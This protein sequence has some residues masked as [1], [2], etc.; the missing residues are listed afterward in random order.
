MPLWK[1]ALP[2]EIRRGA[3]IAESFFDR[4][5]VLRDRWSL[6]NNPTVNG[7]LTLNG[8]NQS[9]T[10]DLN[11]ELLSSE[12]TIEVEFSP[13]FAADDNSE[14]Y[15]VDT[16]GGRTIIVKGSTNT[17]AIY[18]G[19]TTL[20]A[21]ISFASYGS[22]WKQ[23]DRNLLTIAIA[24]G[25]NNIYL[26][27]QTLVSG[28]AIVWVPQDPTI[29]HLGSR[30]TGAS[31]FGG[32]IADFRVG[33]YLSTEQE[34]LD[35][36]NHQAWKW[37]NQSDITLQL[38][39]ADYD[40]TNVQT[41]DSSG[42]GNHFQLGDGSTPTTYPTQEDGR[43]SFDGGDSLRRSSV[44]QPAAAFSVLCTVNSTQPGA[45]QFVASHNNPAFSA[46]NWYLARSSSNQWSWYVGG[47]AVANASIGPDM[48]DSSVHTLVGVYDGTDTILYIDG[49]A[50]T[51][52]TTPL[53]PSSGT[54]TLELGRRSGSAGNHLIGS[55]F[56][57]IYFDNQA[58][59]PV[60]I[61]DYDRTMRSIYGSQV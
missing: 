58:L 14:H 27:G 54:Q 35:R 29:L 34:H 4:A 23:D 49:V 59:T 55:I 52:A 30:F 31:Y 11:G 57:F 51:P 46:I 25:N 53:A 38:R 7:G 21:A 48:P 5:S 37:Q 42:N 40:I 10:Y 2:A 1:D 61:L 26:N 9:A 6:I 32:T 19:A 41:L 60:Q 47:G 33:H 8:T 17:L 22:Y 56:D 18:A 20:V 39:Y 15:I 3:K 45:S 43:M 44:G 13:N 16:T 12:Q 36:W 28:G 50:Q 24:P